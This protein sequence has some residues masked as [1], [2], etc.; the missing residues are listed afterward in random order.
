MKR[1]DKKSAYNNFK[2]LDIDISESDGLITVSITRLFGE[3]KEGLID[4]KDLNK[5]LKIEYRGIDFGLT[6][7]EQPCNFDVAY[8]THNAEAPLDEIENAEWQLM[9]AKDYTFSTSTCDKCGEYTT[10]PVLCNE[11]GLLVI[12]TKCKKREITFDD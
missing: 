9:T 4:Y 3:N 7:V 11:K 12:C 2:D 5:R 10:S 6:L 8:V 1:Q